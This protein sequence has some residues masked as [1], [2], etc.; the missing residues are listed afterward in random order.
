MIRVLP[1]CAMKCTDQSLCIYVH[2]DAA[3]RCE[4]LSKFASFWGSGRDH[5]GINVLLHMPNREEPIACPIGEAL[6]LEYCKRNPNGLRCRPKVVWI[7]GCGML[8]FH[9]K[10]LALLLVLS[11]AAFGAVHVR[12]S[13]TRT[14]TY[15][16][17]HS[18]TSPDHTQHNNYSTRG[19]TNPTQVRV[20][21]GQLNDS[22]ENA[23]RVTTIELHYVRAKFSS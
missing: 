13:R 10:T 4:W 9:V 2:E 1:S 19:N 7:F 17:S 12:S 5:G 8:L 20:T 23:S 18:R 22:H 21:I 14:G 15:W 16:Q 11:T 6:C 3:R